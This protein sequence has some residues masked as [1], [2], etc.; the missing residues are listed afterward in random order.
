MA[1]EFWFGIG[2]TYTYFPVM[3]LDVIE[4][5]AG[6]SFTWRP[7]NLR[8]LLSEMNSSPFPDHSAK[9]AYMWRD[10]ERRAEKYGLTV[11]LPAPYTITDL[12]RAN[13]IALLGLREGWGKDYVRASYRRWFADGQ[14]AGAEPNFS[15]SLRE[16]GQDPAAALERAD[17]PEIVAALE[18]ATDEALSLGIFGSPIFAVDGELFWGHDR[19]DDAVAWARRAGAGGTAD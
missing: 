6:L 3:L 9:R 18:H 13:R 4:R 5:E 1:I 11:S 14:D 19:V 15:E 8:R 10:I 2:S 17:A 16:A 12:L 7:F